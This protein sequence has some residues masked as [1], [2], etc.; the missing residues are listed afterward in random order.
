MMAGDAEED[1]VVN[2]FRQWANPVRT[3]DISPCICKQTVGSS[4]QG[5][6]ETVAGVCCK[7]VF[8]LEAYHQAR[9]LL[10]VNGDGVVC[11]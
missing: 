4:C 2:P 11:L 10:V 6:P 1:M 7:T 5:E 3:D 8:L 9:P